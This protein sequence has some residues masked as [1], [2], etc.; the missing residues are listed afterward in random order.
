MATLREVKKRIRT[1]GSK[2][3]QEDSA[4]RRVMKLFAKLIVLSLVVTLVLALPASARIGYGVK[5]G[6]SFAT[7]SGADSKGYNTQTGFVGGAYLKLN[8]ARN[9]AIQPEVLFSQKGSSGSV[10]TLSTTIKRDF[11][12]DYI[13]IPLL[14]RYT[15]ATEGT[16]T[17]FV[18][19]G[20]SIGFITKAKVTFEAL[21]ESSTLNMANEKTSDFCVVFGGGVE[22]DAGSMDVFIDARFSVGT[23]APFEDVE[24]FDESDVFVNGLDFPMAWE[25]DGKAFELKNSVI[26]VMV[27]IAF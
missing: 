16:A 11:K 25:D 12:I 7:F 26:S 1:V 27:G 9:L 21:G 14:L 24:P 5:G 4:K 20:P 10:R 17:P 3:R 2:K 23:S 15:I 6:L 18:Y 22:L 13:E 8:I 19:A